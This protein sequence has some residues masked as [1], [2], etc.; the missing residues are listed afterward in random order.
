MMV[1]DKLDECKNKNNSSGCVQDNKN[2][3][4]KM[5][6]SVNNIHKQQNQF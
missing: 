3:T 1:R 5:R 6:S 4:T 2:S